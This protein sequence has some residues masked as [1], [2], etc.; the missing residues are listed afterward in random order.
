[1]EEVKDIKIYVYS[2]DLNFTL[3][4]A[5]EEELM[6]DLDSKNLDTTILVNKLTIEITAPTKPYAGHANILDYIKV[7]YTSIK[8]N[9]CRPLN[10]TYNF[11]GG[12]YTW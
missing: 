12:I 6:N 5:D 9:E 10:S 11:N 4:G 2:D 1:M 8:K 3:C 7:F